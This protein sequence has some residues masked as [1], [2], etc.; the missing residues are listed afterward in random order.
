MIVSTLCILI[1]LNLCGCV[2]K[3]YSGEMDA[4][5]SYTHASED[6]YE[7]SIIVIVNEKEISDYEECAWEVL[8]NYL[9]NHFKSIL[10]DFNEQGYPYRLKAVIYL[11]K[12]D[13]ETGSSVFEMVYQA[14]TYEY[15]IKNNPE[16]CDMEIITE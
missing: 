3:K 16:K 5:S 15:N 11:Q 12:D 14:K 8:E 13:I 4:V 7:E 6:C 2:Q 1:G 9:N 10:F